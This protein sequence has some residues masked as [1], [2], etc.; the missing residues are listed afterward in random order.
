[1]TKRI[2]IGLAGATMLA[3]VPAAASA[4]TSWSVTVGNGYRGYYQQYDP[5]GASGSYSNRY[6]YYDQRRAWEARQR[7]QQR[8]QWERERRWEQQRYQQQRRWQEDRSRR[9]REDDD[10]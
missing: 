7:W 10:D 8:Q 1:M 5:Y 6:G 9:D 4:Q 2:L 3:G